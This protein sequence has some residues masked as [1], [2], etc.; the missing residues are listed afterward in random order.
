MINEKILQEGERTDEEDSEHLDGE[1]TE[2]IALRKLEIDREVIKLKQLESQERIRMREI[3]L[4]ERELEREVMRNREMGS[5][6]DRPFDVGKYIKLSPPVFS[7]KN[8]EQYFDSFEKMAK[9]VQWPEDKWAIIL[10]SVLTGRAQ[11]VYTAMSVEDSENYYHVKDRILNAYEQ[12]PESY[13]QKFR[14]ELRDVQ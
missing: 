7:E 8:V 14:A 1:E 9:Q 10:Q 6:R 5:G 3:E 4:R 12:V 11:D 2:T 13:R